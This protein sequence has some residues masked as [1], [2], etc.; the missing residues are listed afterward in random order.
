MEKIVTKV[1][2]FY[3]LLDPLPILQ[4]SCKEDMCPILVEGFRILNLL[5]EGEL[6]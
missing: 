4:H 3:L 6:C 5:I 1:N 2:F